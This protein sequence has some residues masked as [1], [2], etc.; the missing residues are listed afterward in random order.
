MSALNLTEAVNM[1]VMT[2]FD[3]CFCECKELIKA[4]K[5]EPEQERNHK[6]IEAA[7]ALGIQALAETDTWYCVIAFI[8]DVYGTVDLCPPSI[9]QLCTLLHAQVKE[10][11]PCHKVVEMW[12]KNSHNQNHK[13]YSQVVRTY[14]YHILCPTGSY[15]LL[16]EIAE[17]CD[18]LTQTERAALFQLSQTR[19]Y[20]ESKCIGNKTDCTELPAN[21]TNTGLVSVSERTH[22]GL[23]SERTHQN[24][25]KKTAEEQDADNGNNNNETNSRSRKAERRP[26]DFKTV[27]LLKWLYE[28][29]VTKLNCFKHPRFSLLLMA[30]LAVWALIQT[31]TGSFFVFLNV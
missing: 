14:A 24:L 8:T 5:C 7:T 22:L 12:L 4:A 6:L 19:R 18:S 13:Q 23:S 2:K 10:Y 21:L 25:S 29:V 30:I 31:Q 20:E 26:C 11:L 3:Q 16:K 15:E 27:Q 17:N 1:F 28:I 9:I